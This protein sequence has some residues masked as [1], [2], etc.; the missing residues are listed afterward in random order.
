MEHLGFVCGYSRSRE[1]RGSLQHRHIADEIAL[2]GCPQNLFGAIALRENLYFT[3]KHNR[4][5][6]VALTGFE[7]NIAAPGRTPLSDRLK[8]RQLTIVELGES[9]AFGIA[10][11]LFVAL[12]FRHMHSLCATRHNPNPSRG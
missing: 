8:Q 12:L 1:R 7:K 4:Q 9:N 10:I 11:K 6:Q 3:A 2:A 5:T